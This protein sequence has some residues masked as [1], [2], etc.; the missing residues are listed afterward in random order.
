MK[1]SFFYLIVSVLLFSPEILLSQ[2]ATCYSD[3]S[4]TYWKISESLYGSKRLSDCHPN[5]YYNCHGFVMR[6]G[7]YALHIYYEGE[8]INKQIVM[9]AR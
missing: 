6:P 8:L 5:A 7:Q 1:N 4:D 9:I 2:T 3:P